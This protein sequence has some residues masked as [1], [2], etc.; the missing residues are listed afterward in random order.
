M[1]DP[2]AGAVVVIEPRP[3]QRQPGQGVE[4]AAGGAFGETGGGERDVALEHEGEVAP[5]LVRRLA[6]GNGAGDVSGAV[7][8]LGPG[9]DQ[10]QGL[11][12]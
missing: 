5:H 9:I 12:P 11:R 4:L 1:A 3:P 2:V 10:I 8:V 6:D 7:Q